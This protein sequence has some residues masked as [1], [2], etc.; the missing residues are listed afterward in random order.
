MEF[1]YLGVGVVLLV[2]FFVRLYFY[3]EYKKRKGSIDT[4]SGWFR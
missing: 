3:R 4:I 1:V 2:S